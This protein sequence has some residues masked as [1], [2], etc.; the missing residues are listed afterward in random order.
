MGIS[1]YRTKYTVGAS[2]EEYR[3]NMVKVFDDSLWYTDYRIVARMMLNL[4][5]ERSLIAAIIPPYRGHVNGLMGFRFKNHK[6]MVLACGLWG[7]IPFDFFVR[8]MKKSNFNYDTASKL[9]FGE[10][11]YNSSIILRTL[12]L[13]AVG[14]AFKTLIEECFDE[15]WLSDDWANSAIDTQKLYSDPLLVKNEYLR[16]QLL[17]E[18]DV[19]AAMSLGL[20]LEELIQIYEVQFAVLRSYDEDT[21]FDQKGNIVFTNNRSLIGVGMS[22]NDFENLKKTN[23][24]KCVAPITG[25]GIDA[26]INEYTAPFLKCNRIEDYK[27]V[28]K[29]FEERFS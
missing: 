10:D 21:W 9:P 7:T 19:L 28:W 22:R 15:S 2:S 1:I 24:G 16:R 11:K 8:I 14:T 4:S 25:E 27:K 29:I 12:C 23:D 20:S 17:V 3:N 6:D 13:N 18:L 26:Q 5:G